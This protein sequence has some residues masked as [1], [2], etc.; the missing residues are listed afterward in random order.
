MNEDISPAYSDGFTW[1]LYL[2]LHKALHTG[3]WCS[4]EGTRKIEK[5]AKAFQGFS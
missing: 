3:A 2:E 4:W 1:T 5:Q